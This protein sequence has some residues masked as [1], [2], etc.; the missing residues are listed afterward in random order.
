M[1]RTIQYIILTILLSLGLASCNNDPSLQRY[2][3]DNQES[4]NFISQDIPLSILAVDQ[5]KFSEDQKEAYNSVK[6]LNFLGY[7]TTKGDSQAY[8]REL[9]KVKTI[10]KGKKYSDLL[11]FSDKGTKV[12]VKYV[13]EED[14][15]ETDEVVVFGSSDSLGFAVVRLLGDDMSPEKMTT[16]ASALQTSN[17]DSSSVQDIMAFFK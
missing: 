4:T 2:F 10:L 1:Q 3:V 11:E 15:D 8:N 13:G 16:L 6:R 14:D 7:K 17:L 9:A 5:S 12:W